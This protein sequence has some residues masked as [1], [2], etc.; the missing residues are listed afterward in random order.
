MSEWQEV[1]PVVRILC[2]DS[3]PRS[4][5]RTAHHRTP[6]PHQRLQSRR[7]K[8]TPVINALS[9]H[10]SASA[11]HR[12]YDIVDQDIW[13][14]SSQFFALRRNHAL[15]AAKDVEL[16]ATFKEKCFTNRQTLRYICVAD[17]HY[18]PTLLAYHGLDNQVPFLTMSSGAMTSITCRRIAQD[19]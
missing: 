15:V 17:E 8:S 14:K 16:R 4:D 2:S 10:A 19:R 13:R 5:P 11:H 18:F 9:V 3:T 7:A 12:N 1:C 6:K